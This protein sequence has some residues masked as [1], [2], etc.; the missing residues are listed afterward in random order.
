MSTESEYKL[1]EAQRLLF[2]ALSNNRQLV[3]KFMELA[4]NQFTL[5]YFIDAFIYAISITCLSKGEVRYISFAISGLG[6]YSTPAECVDEVAEIEICK[7]IY[8]YSRGI[9]YRFVGG[10][11]NYTVIDAHHW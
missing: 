1:M 9:I 5:Q 8:K 7:D 6:I 4:H 3:E 11:D 10:E 2:A